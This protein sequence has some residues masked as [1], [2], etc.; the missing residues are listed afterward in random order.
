M[1]KRYF[2]TDGIRGKV[3]AGL[4]TPEAF[5][6][7]GIAAGNALAGTH[8]PSRV[9]IGRDTRGS[10]AKLEEAVVAGLFAAGADAVSTG[11]LPTPG[12]AM[13]TKRIGFDFGIM[14]TASHNPST[15]NGIKFFGPDGYKL[16]DE[17]ELAIEQQ[18]D[19]A[20]G[21][22]SFIPRSAPLM[23]DATDRYADIVRASLPR[24]TTLDGLKIVLDCS[25]GAGFNAAPMVLSQLGADLTVIGYQP[26]GRN[27]NQGC[28]ST[29]LTALKAA[30]ADNGADIGI[31]LDGD[32]DR[33]I[34]VDEGGQVVDGDQIMALLTRH[35]HQQGRLKGGGLVATVMS[36]LG[37]ERALEADGL[38]LIRTPVGDRHVVDAM[39][40]G[41]FNIGGE[42]SG[43]IVLG[44]YGTTGDGLMAALPV[45]IAC[46]ASQK[47]ASD[48]CRQFDAVPQLLKN[49]RYGDV[50][51]L[52]DAGI[53][54]QIEVA[55]KDLVGAGRLLIRK[56][57]T[58]PLIRVMAEGD[59]EAQITRIVD[60][61]ILAIEEFANG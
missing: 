1:I 45:L 14:L 2:G 50:D 60:R 35:L 20:E 6:R 59:D 7:L 44:D 5:F 41:G 10:G 49:V 29:D 23:A 19:Q 40:K 27:I 26:D 24:G 56:S 9:L 34:L 52:E 43:H 57:G 11:V 18:F 8:N 17:Q 46:H 22:G 3:G 4:I 42:Q 32:A 54:D 28:G 16:S 38:N 13:L 21:Y 15:D 39:R 37:L 33:L 53:R 12:V 25:N 36:N 48:V 55:E 30:V 58:E 31:A 47:P 51:P 61:L